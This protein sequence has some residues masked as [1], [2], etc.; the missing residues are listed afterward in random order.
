M[1]LFVYASIYLSDNR[2]GKESCRSGFFRLLKKFTIITFHVSQKTLFLVSV[3]Y[4]ILACQL[5]HASLIQRSAFF[6][7]YIKKKFPSDEGRN[8]KYIP[9]CICIYFPKLS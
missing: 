5:S 9:S 1:P 4:A 8:M 3:H 7:N 2:D 6:I